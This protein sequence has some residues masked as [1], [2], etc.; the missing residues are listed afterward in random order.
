MC[1][2][3]EQLQCDLFFGTIATTLQLTTQAPHA[4][5]L[6]WTYGAYNGKLF[7]YNKLYLI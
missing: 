4:F 2:S 1:F 5:Q 7:C 6:D 3:Y